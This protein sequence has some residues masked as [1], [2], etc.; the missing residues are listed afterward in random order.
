MSESHIVSLNKELRKELTIF[1]PKVHIVEY[2]TT[3]MKSS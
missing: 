3:T 1:G 2:D